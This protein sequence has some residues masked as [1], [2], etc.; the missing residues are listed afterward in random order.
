MY[1]TLNSARDLGLV[2]EVALAGTDPSTEWIG[3]DAHY[4]LI[5]TKCGVESVCEGEEIN[6][7]VEALERQHGFRANLAHLA[8]V[9]TCKACTDQTAQVS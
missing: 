3:E 7:L 1:R 4:H 9:G 2:A 5:C 6:H 8:I